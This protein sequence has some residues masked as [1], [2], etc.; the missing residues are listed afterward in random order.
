M[1]EKEDL[2]VQPENV[3]QEEEITN[4]QYSEEKEQTQDPLSEEKS[5]E[6]AEETVECEE[7]APVDNL[8]KVENELKALNDKHLRLIA[9]YDNYRK[10][11]LKE[12][13]DM[14]KTAGEKIFTDIL[15]LIDDFE[16]ALQHIEKSI[17]LKAV[18]DGIELIY[19]KFI[20]FL[21]Q[22][23][24]KEVETTT[25]EFDA[26][27]YEAVA[28]VPAPSAEMKNKI[29]DCVE[30]GYMLDDKVIRYPKVVVGE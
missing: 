9:E 29:M 28:K 27:I 12:K 17:D 1:I 16:R 30:K 7:S 14:S 26:E 10:R 5:T 13:L 21:L 23:G 20:N 3:E 11:T 18:K 22:H 6:T 2:M 8:T 19:N 25:K 4:N 24:V 15:P